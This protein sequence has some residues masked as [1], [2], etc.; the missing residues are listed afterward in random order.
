[1]MDMMATPD[2]TRCP[3]FVCPFPHDAAWTTDALSL[4]WEGLGTVYCFPPPILVKQVLDKMMRASG[5]CLILIA[6]KNALKTWHP[7]LKQM[8][9]EGPWPL[10]PQEDLLWQR[11]HKPQRETV[12]HKCPQLLDLA[13]WK[14]SGGCYAGEAIQGK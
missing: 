3:M 6:S 7:L 5:T 1:M 9:S 8:A 13:A 14:V 12:F 11:I 10:P 2:N 4:A